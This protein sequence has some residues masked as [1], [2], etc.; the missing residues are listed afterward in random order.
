[1]SALVY[2]L[3][4][5]IVLF[6]VVTYFFIVYHLVKYTLHSSLNTVLLPVFIAISTLF[7]I[8]NVMLFAAIDW[9]ELFSNFPGLAR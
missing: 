1:M 8:S 4:G 6:Y 9:A 5:F 3:Y 7:L 2:I